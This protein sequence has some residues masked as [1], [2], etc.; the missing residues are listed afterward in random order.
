MMV[1][2]GVLSTLSRLLGG[3]AK[4][5]AYILLARFLGAEGQGAFA[6]VLTVVVTASPMGAMGLDF[7]N[8]YNAGR[9]GGEA[10]TLLLNS[11]L[12]ALLTGVVIGAAYLAARR[13]L[14]PQV[15]HAVP[16]SADPYLVAGIPIQVM[17]ITFQGVVVGLRRFRD[18]VVATLLNDGLFL[19][20]LVAAGLAGLLTLKMAIALWCLVTGVANV[21][22][23]WRVLSTAERRAPDWR[24]LREGFHYSVWRYAYAIT[25]ALYHRADVY[26]IAHF[27]SAQSIGYYTVARSSA[28]ALMYVPKALNAVVLSYAASDALDARRA[29]LLYRSSVAGLAGAALA[30]ALLA[31]LL[32]PAFFGAEF[33]ASVL[34][35][36]ILVAGIVFQAMGSMAMHH[37]YGLNDPRIPVLATL[38]GLAVAT[39][40]SAVL[41]PRWQLGG[42]AVA[43]AL[44]CVVYM[45]VLFG[46]LASAT[47]IRVADLLVPSLAD[48]RGLGSYILSRA[49]R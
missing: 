5:L 13:F 49:G 9:R 22:L 19:A 47:R 32:L 23:A 31:G 45:A 44:S 16:R 14:D 28:E 3:G 21:Y 26:V 35:F 48:Y 25:T 43:A 7:S 2:D 18:V 42:A 4:L 17:F 37:L 24:L 38:A 40:L 30:M 10:G 20:C 39:G 34:P 11:A 33:A 41:V 6:M 8:A 46:R 15:L 1:R 29:G 36:R 12:V 27:M